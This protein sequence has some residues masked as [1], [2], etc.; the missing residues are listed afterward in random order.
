[1]IIH[2]SHTQF[3]TNHKMHIYI[4]NSVYFLSVAVLFIFSE[5][6]CIQR[7]TNYLI[8]EW[9]TVSLYNEE[10]EHL[11]MF[12]ICFIQTPQ[13]AHSINALI[14]SNLCYHNAK[15]YNSF[16]YRSMT[17]NGE[18]WYYYYHEC[19]PGTQHTKYTHNGKVTFL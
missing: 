6:T 7:L 12:I 8:K 11:Q 18:A 5:Y 13:Q 10:D 15:N 17:I 4:K 2:Q 3:M 14:N 9:L 1:M 19:I 16:V